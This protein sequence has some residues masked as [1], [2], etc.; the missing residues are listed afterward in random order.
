MRA[1]AVLWRSSLWIFIFMAIY[2]RQLLVSFSSALSVCDSLLLWFWWRI[3]VSLSVE[4]T[5]RWSA[6][7]S[8][9]IIIFEAR[10]RLKIIVFRATISDASGQRGDSARWVFHCLLTDLSLFNSKT[11][12]NSSRR[13]GTLVWRT[14]PYE[15]SLSSFVGS[16]DTENWM[17]A[18]SIFPRCRSV[19]AGERKRMLVPM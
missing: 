14:P 3:Q 9:R 8:S 17:R 6:T 15:V 4:W 10:C 12:R 5:P 7:F 1:F 16:T 2:M 11:K 13:M 18:L 19:W